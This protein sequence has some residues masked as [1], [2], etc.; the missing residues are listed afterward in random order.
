M[1]NPKPKWGFMEDGWMRPFSLTNETWGQ[2]SAIVEI[3]SEELRSKLETDAG[4]YLSLLNE[5]KE[6]PRAGAVRACL[7][8]LSS[9][10]K[11][12]LPSLLRRADSATLE[13]L[14]GSARELL[15]MD[16]KCLSV[17][18]IFAEL[19]RDRRFLERVIA[20]ADSRLS[21]GAPRLDAQRIFAIE[22]AFILNSFGVP[23]KNAVS[24][25]YDLGKTDKGKGGKFAQVL[26]LM[27]SACGTSLGELKRLVELGA[28]EIRHTLP[29]K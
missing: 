20:E 22:V 3:D 6:R 23:I 16:Q 14:L 5:E 12:Q 28:K 18:E 26:E 17:S 10:S 2:I 25:K 27:L 4:L 1:G 29:K 24:S 9:A 11:S 21:N 7:R 19:T 13:S 15:P 8:E